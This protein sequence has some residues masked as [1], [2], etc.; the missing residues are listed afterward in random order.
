MRKSAE[1]IARE[2]DALYAKYQATQERAAVGR[3]M[4]IAAGLIMR[5]WGESV[6]AKHILE[7][8]GYDSIE[9]MKDDGVDQYDIDAV[10]TL[11]NQ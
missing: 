2:R 4:V 10:A 1:Q 8:A 3:G 11:F 9:K 5:A 7:C 6:Q